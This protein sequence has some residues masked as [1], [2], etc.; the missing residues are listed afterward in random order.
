MTHRDLDEPTLRGGEPTLPILREDPKPPL[1]P[2]LAGGA[3][4]IVLLL[5]A[6][7]LWRGRS[8]P[9][10][11]P[12][13]P[14][15]VG[16]ETA[17]ASAPVPATPAPAIDTALPALD[18]SD[19]WLRGLVSALSA[20]PELAA[21]LVPE[22]LIRRFVAAVDNVAEGVSPSPH[23]E[24]LRPRERFSARP[25]AGRTVADPASHR[26]YDRLT[27]VFVS[28]DV[29]AGARLYRRMHP[30]L[31]EAYRELGYP[32][33]TFDQTLAQAIDRLLAV[34]IPARSLELVPA[35]TVYAYAE[36]RL[37]ALPA[38]EKHL[39]RLGPDN[40]RRVQGKLRQVEAAL[41]LGGPG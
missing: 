8:G 4:A 23:L 37:E 36:P 29:E 3:V 22:H 5:A 11:G 16:A 15:A 33:R 21:W 13:G 18:Q 39:L 20:Q 26:R 25:F 12:A 41:A 2:W 30:L 1:G 40:A 14:R 35:A 6:L 17:P 34:E 7:W 38:A 27:E 9:A 24:H 28:L 32:G 19:E 10:A 31:E